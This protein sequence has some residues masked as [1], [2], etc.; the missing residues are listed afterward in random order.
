MDDPIRYVD[1]F[2]VATNNENLLW[3]NSENLTKFP[4]EILQLIH[5]R[6]LMLQ[7]NRLSSLPFDICLLTNLTSLHLDSNLFTMIPSELYSLTSLQFLS[8]IDNQLTAIP[9][10]IIKLTN[11]SRLVLVGNQISAIPIE[12]GQMSNLKVLVLIDNKITTVPQELCQSSLQAI[13]LEQ[14]PIINIPEELDDRVRL[15]RAGRIRVS[16]YRRRKRLLCK[17]QIAHISL[18]MILTQIE[19]PQLVVEEI[20]QGIDN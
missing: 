9:S 14:N 17:Y 16:Q 10:D 7:D 11:L 13:F 18:N 3:R 1:M 4:L 2:G 15:D 6:S 12:L 20:Y 8:V 19:I 5:L